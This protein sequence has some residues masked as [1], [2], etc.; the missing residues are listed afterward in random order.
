[1]IDLD[2]P[3][4]LKLAR[5]MVM[6]IRPYKQVFADFGIDETD[7]YAI[8]KNP[9]YIKAHEHLTQEW[10]ATTSTADRIKSKSLAGLEVLLPKMIARAGSPT[11]HLSD[12]IDAAKHLARNAGIGEPG[13]ENKPSDRFIISINLGA[14]TEGNPIIETYDKSIDVDAADTSIPVP[15][16]PSRGRPKKVIENVK[17]DLES[18]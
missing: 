10:N 8:V 2:E 11:E 3:T 7:Y 9:Y 14:D 16:K 17:I 6:N 15:V 1:M 12:M 13:K 4:L 18:P 5:E